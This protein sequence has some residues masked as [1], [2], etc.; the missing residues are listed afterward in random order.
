[1]ES[2]QQQQ[3]QHQQRQQ[4]QKYYFFFVSFIYFTQFDIRQLQAHARRCTYGGDGNVGFLEN[5]LNRRANHSKMHT[6]T[7]NFSFERT[8]GELI[9]YTQASDMAA[10]CN[11][12]D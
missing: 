6:H 8:I 12:N 11:I 10:D 1:M 4:K 3:N 2:E 5:E 7:D 9:Q